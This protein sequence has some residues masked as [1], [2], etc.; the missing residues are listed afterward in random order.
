MID[1]DQFYVLNLIRR[2]DRRN[3]IIGEFSKSKILNNRYHFFESVDGSK[4]NDDDI[5]C[6]KSVLSDIAIQGFFNTE[7]KQYGLDFTFGSYG[8]LLT[9]LKLFQQLVDTNQ[10]A[11]IFEDDIVIDNNFDVVLTNIQT[12]LPTNFDLCYLGYCCGE[13]YTTI[14]YSEHLVIPRGQLNCL[15]GYVISPKGA[16]TIL[17]L[18]PFDYQID[19]QLYLNFETMNVFC[20]KIPI[21]KCTHEFL[22][23]GQS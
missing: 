7:N 4:M 16:K 14:E 13:S 11:L 10:C 21:V 5:R 9:Y 17:N 20:S 2:Q 12:E 22:S 1:I 18:K 23:D 15:Y 19:T 6:D 3:H 8:I